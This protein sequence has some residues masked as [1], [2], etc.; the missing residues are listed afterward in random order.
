MR[1]VATADLHYNIPRSVVPTEHVAAKI[2]RLGGDAL[3]ILG[4]AC[5]RDL[6]ILRRCFSLFEHFPGQV[7]FVAGNHDIW[8]YGQDSLVRYEKEI[9]DLCREAGV[10]YLDAEPYVAG[11]VAIVG[12]MGWYDYSFRQRELGIPIRFYE[13]KVGPGAAARMDEHRHLVEGHDDLPAS[14]LEV[15]TR[16]MDGVFVRLPMMDHEFTR[17]LCDQLAGQLRAVEPQVDQIVVGM[18]HVPFA[19][20]VKGSGRPSYDFANAFMGSTRFGDLLLAS[21]KVRHMVCGHSHNRQHVQCGHIACVNVG[22]TYLSKRY[23]VLDVD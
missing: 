11:G 14:A 10:W 12:C 6:G 15:T 4:D 2:N 18:H 1:I 22:S 7:F 3:L 19:S 21:P 13:R 20:M 17:R 23:V 5:G 9:A 16:W 8:T